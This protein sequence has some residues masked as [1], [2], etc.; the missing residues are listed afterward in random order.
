MIL[1]CVAWNTHII[2]HPFS[3]RAEN[4]HRLSFVR[5]SV[6]VVHHHVG[7]H[8]PLGNVSL[9]E[10]V[11][12]HYILHGRVNVWLIFPEYCISNGGAVGA[13]ALGDRWEVLDG[14]V[15]PLPLE[16]LIS[17]HLQQYHQQQNHKGTQIYKGIS[18]RT[19]FDDQQI[20]HSST[21]YFL[22]QCT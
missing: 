6:Q 9:A 7:L 5:E 12:L 19:S 8:L 21:A 18:S 16:A 14:R 22:Q 1:F 10:I 13:R 2:Y 3:T 11:L 4:Y 15:G 20:L 17:P